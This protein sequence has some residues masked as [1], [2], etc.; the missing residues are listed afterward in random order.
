MRIC[1]IQFL[2]DCFSRNILVGPGLISL[3]FV[4]H[5][6]EIFTLYNVKIVC[7]MDI[8]RLV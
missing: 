8:S 5:L 6:F 1:S 4:E 3:G 2:I 7:E